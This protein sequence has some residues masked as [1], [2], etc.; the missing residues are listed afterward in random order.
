M[1][2]AALTA[3]VRP[4]R[5]RC[6]WRSSGCGFLNRFDS[7]SS[8][9]TNSGGDSVC[10]GCWIAALDAGVSR[11]VCWSHEICDGV[12][13]RSTVRVPE[14]V[15]DRVRVG[16][17]SRWRCRVRCVGAVD[18]VLVGCFDWRWR[19]PVRAR[20]L[21]VGSRSSCW[22]WWFIPSVVMVGRGPVTRD[23]RWRYE[24]SFSGEVP[25]WAPLRCSC[26]TRCGSG[27]TCGVGKMMRGSFDFPR[28]IG[29]LGVG[30][31]GVCQDQLDLAG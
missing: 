30:V 1:R 22:R 2:G 28:Q 12:I 27:E 13:R 6:R 21:R 8:S 9:Q 3:R 31:G 15:C 14:V 11:H 5:C 16:F 24:A 29:F 10:R 19:F 23:V 17:G 25:G 26:D 18:G 7:C 4:E 20:C